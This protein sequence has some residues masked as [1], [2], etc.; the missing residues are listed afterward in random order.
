M[1]YSAVEICRVGT[2]SVP[3]KMRIIFR[4]ENFFYS[5]SNGEQLLSADISR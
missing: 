4:V 3:N 1:I 5:E 2:I